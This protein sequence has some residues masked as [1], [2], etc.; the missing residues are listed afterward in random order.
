MSSDDGT[1][2]IGC[3]PAHRK[4]RRRRGSPSAECKYGRAEEHVSADK[5]P[6]LQQQQ[7][8]LRCDVSHGG[9][10]G[11][12]PSWR[13]AG[14]ANRFLF[15]ICVFNSREHQQ[16]HH[17]LSQSVDVEHACPPDKRC[18]PL[19]RADNDGDNIDDEDSDDDDGGGGGNMITTHDL[20]N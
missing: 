11:R 10:G 16:Q 4:V 9:G 7:L 8:P 17:T 5:S 3:T 6:M 20:S 18:P 1:S 14:K 12:Q 15:S 19:G 13:A 2:S